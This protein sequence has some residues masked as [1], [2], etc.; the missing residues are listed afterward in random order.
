M[1]IPPHPWRRMAIVA[2]SSVVLAWSG[3]AT[4]LQ[5]DG[6]ASTLIASLTSDDFTDLTPLGARLRDVRIVQ[7]GESSH[8]AAEYS[9]IKSRLVR[10][11][12]QVQGFDL[13]LFESDPYLCA[14][15]DRRAAEATAGSTLR[16]CVFGV[17]HT[18]EVLELFE[19]V[20]STRDTARPLMIGGYDIQP[21]GPGKDSRPAWLAGV[22]ATLDP[23]YAGAIQALDAEFLEIYGRGNPGRRQH[24]RTHRA[25]LLERFGDLYAF[26]VRN[27]RQL[28]ARAP[29]DD[30]LAPLLAQQVAWSTIQYVRQQTAP[31]DVNYMEERDWGMARNL[32]LAADAM[33]PGSR[34]IVW[35]HNAHVAHNNQ[36]IDLTGVEE[37]TIQ[38]RGAGSWLKERYGPE[39]FTIGLYAAAGQMTRNDR[40][41]IT[42][43]PVR[44]GSLEAHA[45]LAGPPAA[46]FI[47]VGETDPLWDQPT[48]A[49]YWGAADL[50]M[51]LRDQ[52]DAV[53]VLRSVSP[54]RYLP[55]G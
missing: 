4:A 20:R 9:Q 51:T 48:T 30:R 13:L 43:G 19:Y 40:E 14:R 55:S 37:P 41:V 10:Y 33:H 22:V 27:E 47:A 25:D 42:V 32:M 52:Y 3:P 36:L 17:W 16:S 31:A 28:V 23:E 38:S 53:I 18:E 6:P 39:L 49:K 15:A 26:L 50:P 29:A 8:G 7:L 45:P 44:P 5:S 21:I 1:Q 34:I 35:A 54:P 24:L 2:V 12:H 46:L 11:L